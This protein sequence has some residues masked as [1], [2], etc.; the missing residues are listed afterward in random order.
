MAEKI[1]IQ[2]ANELALERDRKALT[3]AINDLL[4]KPGPDNGPLIKKLEDI[5][6]FLKGLQL[7]IDAPQVIVDMSTVTATMEKY[8]AQIQ[9]E[10]VKTQSQAQTPT[11]MKIEFT[12]N[13]NGYI[14]SPITVTPV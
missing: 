5:L 11:A 8:M 13:G 4:A 9:H 6:T 3:K 2:E 10:I 14:Q 1:S 12:R 7:N